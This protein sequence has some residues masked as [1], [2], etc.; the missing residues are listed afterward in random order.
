MR[1]KSIIPRCE[2]QSSQV[3]I[4]KTSVYR[5]SLLYK[6][7][8]FATVQKGLELWFLGSNCIFVSWRNR[9]NPYLKQLIV[10]GQYDSWIQSLI[11]KLFSIYMVCDLGK[12]QW[13]KANWPSLHDF[14]PGLNCSVDLYIY[15]PMYFVYRN[16]WYF[17]TS[18]LRS[19]SYLKFQEAVGKKKASLW[20]FEQ[21]C[22]R[23]D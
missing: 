15:R 23:D 8:K 18:F 14:S 6:L 20:N 16:V 3:L 5:D 12:N 7:F 4:F 2:C 22:L 10:C 21:W 1:M 9:L 19:P 17:P 13:V 11:S